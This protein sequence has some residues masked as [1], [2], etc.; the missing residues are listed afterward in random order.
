[1]IPALGCGQGMWSVLDTGLQL[2]QTRAE[3]PP[4]LPPAHPGLWIPVWGLFLLLG[5]PFQRDFC[6]W[7]SVGARLTSLPPA[8]SPAFLG[9]RFPSVP[10]RAGILCLGCVSP[11]IN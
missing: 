10:G 7:E 2:P 8:P 5:V 6:A 3:L 4:E 11:G 9:K 1:M